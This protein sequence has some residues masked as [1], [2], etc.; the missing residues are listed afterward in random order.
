M[1]GRTRVSILVLCA[2]L[3]A[4]AGAASAQGAAEQSYPRFTLGADVGFAAGS[5]SGAF[6]IG[7][8]APIELNENFSIGPWLQIL[9]ARGSTG[10]LFSGNARYVFTG[11][12]YG[13]MAKVRPFVQGGMG[14]G[15]TSGRGTTELLINMGFGFEYPLNENVYMGSDMMFNTLPT[16]GG[17]GAFQFSWQ[18]VSLRYKF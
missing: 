17:G 16:A 7:F 4:V 12:F 15:Y 6:D 1:V 8:E 9:M 18:F 5:G 3:L 13:R 14:L 2:A 11:L 10:I